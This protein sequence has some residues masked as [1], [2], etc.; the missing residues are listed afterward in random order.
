MQDYIKY[1]LI[2]V[3][4]ILAPIKGILIGVGVLVFFDMITAIYA[5]KKTGDDITSRKLSK[6]IGKLV[7]Y[8]IAVLTGFIFEKLLGD[9]IPVIK[10]ISSVLIMTELFSIFENF[11]KATGINIIQK[12]KEAFKREDKD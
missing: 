3:L 12:L 2:S 4:G 9:F 8:N 1:L 11:Y 10:I 6:T 5:A 7:L